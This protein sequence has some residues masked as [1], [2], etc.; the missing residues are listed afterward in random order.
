MAAEKR[1][2]LERKKALYEEEKQ[3]I[4]EEVAALKQQE[5][6]LTGSWESRRELGLLG[7][8]V[9]LH[10]LAKSNRTVLW[11]LLV[12]HLFFLTIE[13]MPLVIKVSYKGSQY[14]DIIDLEE[15]QCLDAARQLSEAETRSLLMKGQCQLKHDEA[16]MN[17]QSLQTEINANCDQ[18]ACIADALVKSAQ[19]AA[20]LEALAEEK[21][22]G[23]KLELLKKRLDDLYGSLLQT[24]Q[25]E[26]A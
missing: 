24:S 15:R 9:G 3:R 2:A 23:E 1:N 22:K 5:A 19:K 6:Q 25:V 14:Y 8:I 18:F 21:V 16:Q 7:A 17:T 13:L 10:E 4:T 26:A 11:I 12:A 20:E